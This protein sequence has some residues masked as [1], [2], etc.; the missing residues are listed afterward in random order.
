MK[1]AEGTE[2]EML[3]ELAKQ[4]PNMKAIHCE[5]GV[6]L[7]IACNPDGSPGGENDISYL[8]NS[9]YDW[10]SFS[11]DWRNRPLSKRAEKELRDSE[12]PSW[13]SLFSFFKPQDSPSP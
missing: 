10:V 9:E 13:Y 1:Y 12:D 3:V 4:V 2:D 5:D 11:T 6:L 7:H 8:D